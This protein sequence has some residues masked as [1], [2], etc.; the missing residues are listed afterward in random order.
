MP[1]FL[2]PKASDASLGVAEYG[3]CKQCGASTLMCPTT[4]TERGL[5]CPDC[6]L[7]G[8]RARRIVAPVTGRIVE[9][10]K[11]EEEIRRRLVQ[12]TRERAALQSQLRRQTNYQR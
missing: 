10:E 4:Q 3:S 9:L 12:I 11:E 1:Y 2:V 8:Y 5:I 6:L 7:A